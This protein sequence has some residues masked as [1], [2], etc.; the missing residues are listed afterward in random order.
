MLFTRTAG[1]ELIFVSPPAV[2]MGDDVREALN[3]AGVPFSDEP[4]LARAVS[5]ADVV[6]QTRVQRERFASED[7]YLQ[8]R[9]VYLIDRESMDAMKPD[10]ILLH[11]LPRVDEIAVEV[12][13]DPRAAYFRQAHNGVYVRMALLDLLLRGEWSAQE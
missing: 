6:Y 3:Q 7:E 9:G 13:A 4:D 10:A 2:P 1:C 12:D 5:T 11:P 8:S